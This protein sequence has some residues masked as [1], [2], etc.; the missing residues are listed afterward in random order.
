VVQFAR[1]M[2]GNHLSLFAIKFFATRKDYLGEVEVYRFSPLRSFM[3]SVLH[4]ESNEDCRMRDPF[5][6]LIPP[7]IVME[8]GESLQER[9]RN[10]RIDVFTAAQ[11]PSLFSIMAPSIR[12]KK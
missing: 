5:G 10:C 2:D 11:V 3:P 9:S 7:F 1:R 12:P 8:K 4:F 6:G